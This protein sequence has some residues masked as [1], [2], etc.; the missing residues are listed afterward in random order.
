MYAGALTLGPE[1]I[2]AKDAKSSYVEGP[3]E[4]RFWLKI[5]NRDFA[6]KEPVEFRQNRR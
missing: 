5:K 3:A 4:N 1:G 6:G 2:V